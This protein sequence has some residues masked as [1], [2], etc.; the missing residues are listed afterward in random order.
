MAILRTYLQSDATIYSEYPIVNTGLDEILEIGTYTGDTSQRE[1][2]RSLIT[3]DEEYI[4]SLMQEYGVLGNYK[5]DLGLFLAEANEVPRSFSIDLYPVAES[6]EEGIGKFGDIPIDKT[7][8]SWGYRNA[9]STDPWTVNNFL[10]GITGSFDGLTIGGGS[11]YSSISSS[12]SKISYEVRKKE[13]LDCK[14]DITSIVNYHI[15]GTIDNNGIVLKLEESVE[16]IPNRNIRVKFFGSNTNTVYAPF[17]DITWDDSSYN[18]GSLP[19]LQTSNTFIKINNNKGVYSLNEAV[20]FKLSSRPKFPVRT[21]E[22]SSIY[23]KNYALPQETYWSIVDEDTNETIVK[24]DNIGTKVSC[25]GN[26]P[27]FKVYMNILQPER[28][29]RVL[30]KSIIDDSILVVNDNSNIFKVV[31]NV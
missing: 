14:I 24:F 28:Y 12:S 5:I 21:F 17:L 1:V 27:Y 31:R 10:E 9:N 19:I 25:D 13:D 7:G 29:Y 3:Y 6:W 11:W 2:I 8:V 16:R 30:I 18:T 20:K 22:T 23:L 4:N 15:S 26:G